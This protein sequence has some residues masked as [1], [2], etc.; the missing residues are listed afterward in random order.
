MC[1]YIVYYE[2]CVPIIIVICDWQHEYA[3]LSKL[4]CPKVLLATS[5]PSV[6]CWSRGMILAL[7]A[8]GPGFNSR[9]S[10]FTFSTPI[11][12]WYPSNLET[13]GT[14]ETVSIP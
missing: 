4:Y 5:L 11:I 10:P 1:A 13:N 12:G 3:V 7:G 8:R 2:Q 6:A 9:T 14:E